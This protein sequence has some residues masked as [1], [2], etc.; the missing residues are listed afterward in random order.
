MA[1]RKL[2][3]HQSEVFPNS[4][5]NAL[6]GTYHYFINNMA[7]PSF[8]K[9]YH[10]AAY[11]SIDP[12]HNAALSATG[13]S[14]FIT[15]GGKGIG[16]E[17]ASWFAKADA[18]AI[19][20]TGRTKSSLD[21]AKIEIQQSYP[22][23][24]IETYVVDIIDTAAVDLAFKNFVAKH[25][26]IDILV[27]NA[28]FLN[29]SKSPAHSF[30]L[31]DFW[32]GF[33]INVKGSFIVTNAFLQ[34]SITVEQGATVIAISS[35]AA[36]IMPLPNMSGY[37]ASK[38]ASAKVM[39]YVAAENVGRGLRVFNLH[40]GLIPTEMATKSGMP[41]QDEIGELIARALDRD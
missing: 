28:G 24:E 18:K 25:G 11:P 27:N 1:I 20:L 14:V 16:R 8:T 30:P 36:H 32:A 12:S 37:A 2:W 41:P 6:R 38:L 31:Q 13:K 7:F 17:I 33:E 15:G 23:V 9:T 21:E 5:T 29:D 22:K 39:E 10:N 26:A 34:P 35:G 4:I 40:P 3:R 19:A